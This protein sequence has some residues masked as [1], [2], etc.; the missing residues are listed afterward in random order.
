MQHSV[1]YYVIEFEADYKIFGF[2]ER[3]DAV[4]AFCMLMSIFNINVSEYEVQKALREKSYFEAFCCGNV[5]I[6]EKRMKNVK[7]E[8]P[9]VSPDE[10]AA[11]LALMEI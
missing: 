9:E 2:I 11:Q 6:R 10:L 1:I 5:S 4:T 3:S 8:L 7:E